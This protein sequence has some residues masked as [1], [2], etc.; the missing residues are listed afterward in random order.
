MFVPRLANFCRTKVAGQLPTKSLPPKSVPPKSLPRFRLRVSAQLGAWLIGLALCASLSV[1]AGPREQALQ[2]H[3]R[4]A[5]VPPSE[6]VLVQMTQLIQANAVNEAVALALENDAF[7]SVTLKNMAAPWTNREHSAF[8][9]L[10][11]YTATVI[12]LVRDNEDFR[13]LLYDDVIYIGDPALGLPAYNNNNNDHYQ[14]LER[15]GYSLKT[16]LVKRA[17]STVTGLPIEATSGILTTRAAAQ[18]F[19]YAGTNRAMFR[20]TLINHLCRDLEQV[21]DNSLVPDRI[22]Q[23]VSRSPGGDSR[24]FMNNCIGCHTGMDPM[25]QA[26]AYYDYKYDLDTDPEGINGS[27]HYN[28]EGE[29]DPTTGTRVTKKYHINNSTFRYGYV[30][31]DDQWDNYWRTGINTSL[32][33]DANLPGAGSGARSMGMELAYSQAFASCQVEKVFRKVCLRTPEN[34][35]DRNQIT[36]TTARFANNGY[37]LKDVFVAAADYCKGE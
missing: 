17:Q 29:L 32:G 3:N 18:A 28:R 20:Y 16:Q 31:P 30:T 23:D 8:V 5:G 19:F 10:N 2:I 33:W 26:F 21:H 14:A 35:A 13:K 15:Q 36:T 9:A 27:I 7:Y 11:D 34:A 4:V 1:Y 25:T 6:A 22:R 37:H 24:V 12:G